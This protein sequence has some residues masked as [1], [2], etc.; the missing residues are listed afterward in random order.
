MKNI[1]MLTI[2]VPFFGCA[3]SPFTQ[4]WS[5]STRPDFSTLNRD[6]EKTR[7]SRSSEID[8]IERENPT[9]KNAYDEDTQIAEIT[10]KNGKKSGY[11]EIRK[12]PENRQ[13]TMVPSIIR[14]LRK[15]MWNVK[16]LRGKIAMSRIR[17]SCPKTNSN[18]L[19]IFWVFNMGDSGHRIRKWWIC[20]KFLKNF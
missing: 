15:N 20:K 5:L 4:E 19:F 3:H 11:I 13:K 2:M 18:V 12:W 10:D 16:H 6:F 7:I 8:R 9:W 14:D 1:I 17:G